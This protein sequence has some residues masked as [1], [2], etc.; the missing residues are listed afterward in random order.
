MFNAYTRTCEKRQVAEKINED[1]GLFNR[2][3]RGDVLDLGTFCDGKHYQMYRK[4]SLYRTVELLV[5]CCGSINSLR[6]ELNMWERIILPW[7]VTH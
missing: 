5:D 6:N 2:K 4:R 3:H 7:R 1:G